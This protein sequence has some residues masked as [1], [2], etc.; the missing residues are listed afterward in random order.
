M[1]TIVE[2]LWGDEPP[3]AAA[4]NVASLVSRLRRALGPD[5]ISGG[6]AGYRL[7]TARA[8]VD[9]DVAERSVAEASVSHSEAEPRSAAVSRSAA[10][11][12]KR[13]INHGSI[14]STSLSRGSPSWPA[15]RSM[16]A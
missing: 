13:S 6:R 14:S 3:P 4:Q 8:V 1:D 9:V 16:R 11:G 2:T 10:C 7:E 5:A 15:S 12:A